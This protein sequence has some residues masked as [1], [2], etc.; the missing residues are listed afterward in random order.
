MLTDYCTVFTSDLLAS[1]RHGIHGRILKLFV[2]STISLKP[3]NIVTT[4][5]VIWKYYGP[6]DL[7]NQH[8]EKNLPSFRRPKY[9]FFHSKMTRTKM[10][11]CAEFQENRPINWALL[12]EYCC[13]IQLTNLLVLSWVVRVKAYFANPWVWSQQLVFLTEIVK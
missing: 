11:V 7:K 10:N 3:F 6:I 12:L 4:K 13:F 9:I 1:L 8:Y 5:R 2:S